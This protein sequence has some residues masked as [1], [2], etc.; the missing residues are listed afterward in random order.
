VLWELADVAQARQKR[1]MRL[2][3]RAFV[4]LALYLS[5]QSTVVIVAGFHPHHSVLGIVWTAVTANASIWRRRL[6]RQSDTEVRE[7]DL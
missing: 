7:P 1:A 4:A 6:G 5:V 3:G 2:I